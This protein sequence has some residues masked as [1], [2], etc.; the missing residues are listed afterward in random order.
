M[1]SEPPNAGTQWGDGAVLNTNL[2]I[3]GSS[4]WG[5]YYLVSAAGSFEPCGY[6]S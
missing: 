2:E 6:R 3:D 1:P 4:G 5:A